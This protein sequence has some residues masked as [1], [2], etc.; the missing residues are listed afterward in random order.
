MTGEDVY[1]MPHEEQADQFT[2]DSYY[3]MI[4][5]GELWDTR[6]ARVSTVSKD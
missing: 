3:R 6:A 1:N 2:L 4:F 5:Q